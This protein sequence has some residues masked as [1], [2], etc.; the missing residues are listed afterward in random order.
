MSRNRKMPRYNIEDVLGRL[1]TWTHDDDRLAGLPDPLADS[2]NGPPDHLVKLWEESFLQAIA[3]DHEYWQERTSRVVS[4]SPTA[5][6]A[7]VEHLL[8][9]ADID[10]DIYAQIM[11][12]QQTEEPAPIAVEIPIRKRRRWLHKT[13]RR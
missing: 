6:A 10:L 3:A 12:D 1:S 11:A 9:P 5:P 7:P 8:D 13:T 4:A 2:A